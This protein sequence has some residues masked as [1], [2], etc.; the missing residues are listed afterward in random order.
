MED[1]TIVQISPRGSLELKS[2]KSDFPYWESGWKLQIKKGIHN[3]V[4]KHDTGKIPVEPRPTCVSRQHTK[5][6]FSTTLSFIAL[7][8]KCSR[9]CSYRRK[10]DPSP[11]FSNGKNK[12]Q[13]DFMKTVAT[14]EA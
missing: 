7:S 9:Q 11:Y 14:I 10:P 3:Y 6:G 5:S 2:S 4:N 13:K 8:L 12:A 1:E